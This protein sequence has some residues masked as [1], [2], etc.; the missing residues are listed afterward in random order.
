MQTTDDEFFTSQ[1]F[2]DMQ[3][4]IQQDV[5]VSTNM[6]AFKYFTLSPSAN[7]KEVWYF[8]SIE[9]NYD[10]EIEEV[11]TDTINGFALFPRI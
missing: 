2:Q 8:E 10:E 6:K 11:V 4:G 9:K 5:A 1:M 3:S 7:Y